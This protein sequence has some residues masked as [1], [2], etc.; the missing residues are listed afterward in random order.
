MAW[1]VFRPK[2]LEWF[3]GFFVAVAV[4]TLAYAGASWWWPWSPGRWG[5]LAFGTMAA[6]LFLVDSLYPLRRR[7][8]AWPFGTAQ[9]WLQFHLYGGGLAS[10]FVLFHV[11]FQAPEGQFGWWLLTL[12]LWTTATGL[13]GVYLQK[14][15]PLVLASNLSVEAIYERIPELSSRLQGEADR[16]LAGGPDLIQRFYLDDLRAWLGTLSPS[17]SYVLDVRADRER[18]MA[19]FQEM[20][21]YLSEPDRLRFSD[22]Q[23]IVSEKMELDIHYSLQR[24]IRVWIPL[25]A[26]PAIV[27]MGML[28]VHIGAVLLF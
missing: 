10:L 4:S 20:S 11:G 25:H 28:V 15:V 26:V 12:S 7:L 5:G 18:R 14:Y 23:A 22:L 13:L 1:T 6:V 3:R 17:W 24:L 21:A 8:M 9:R 27:L 16:L 2:R 19:P